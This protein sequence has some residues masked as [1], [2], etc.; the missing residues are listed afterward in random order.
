MKTRRTLSATLSILG[1]ILAIAGPLLPGGDRLVRIDL[2]DEGH[3]TDLALGSD[4]SVLAGTQAG[5]VWRFRDGL[6]EPDRVDSDDQPI[7]ALIGDPD[8]NPFGTASGLKNP[9]AASPPLKGRVTSLLQTERGLLVGTD[10]GVQIQ[11]GTGWDQPGPPVNVYS[12]HQQVRGDQ[13]YLH[14]GTVDGGAYSTTLEDMS[15][16]WQA[17]SDGL[18]E[19]T[20]LFCFA[21]TSG[22]ILL[23]GT[24]RGIYWQSE[25]GEHWHAL[26]SVLADQRILSLYPAP[27][28]EP[29]T[30]RLW[31]GTDRGLFALDFTEQGAGLATEGSLIA[32]D[33]PA[34][35]PRYG[36]SW[37][38]PTDD[39][40]MISA[41]SVYQ[42]GPTHIRGWYW[43]SLVGI[44]LIVLGGWL[45]PQR[46]A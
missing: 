22:G 4:A 43:I 11:T 40:L 7:T 24:S 27:H 3:V 42:Y 30:Q 14:A 17:N 1:L 20:N 44:A 36:I 2:P 28:G 29:G 37:I 21:D 25:P 35:E 41:G 19:G 39:G 31:I 34:G 6:W 38:V 32:A 9:P 16:A 8:S 13:R 18:P 5:E 12:L 15:R 45:M 33:A 46:K 10:N 23:A 26:H